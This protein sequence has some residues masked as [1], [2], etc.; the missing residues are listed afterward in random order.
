MSFGTNQSSS[1]QQSQSDTYYDPTQ[2]GLID[3]YVST[4]PTVASQLAYTPYTGPG[5]S[6]GNPSALGSLTSY[7]APTVSGSSYAPSTI[8]PSSVGNVQAGQIASTN[9]SPYMNPYTSDVADTTAAQLARQNQIQ[10]TNDAAQATSAGAFGGSRSAVLQSLDDDNYQ[11]DLN[12]T[13]AGLN[14][15]N[16]TQAQGAAQT[17]I[18]NQLQAGLQDQ[19]ADLAVDQANQSAA[20][21]AG[22]FGA[23]EAQNAAL[24]NQSAAQAAAQ[25]QLSALNLGTQQASDLYGANWQQYLN[26]QTA[27]LAVQQV[28]NQMYGLVPNKP[29]DQSD[30][31][32]TS[33]S[34]GVNFGIG[35]LSGAFNSGSNSNS[36]SNSSKSS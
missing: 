30:S 9:L 34:D 36:N 8:D 13:L 26:S 27:P 15:A 31:S 28:I 10:Q 14:Q 20:N 4:A 3:Q 32:S 16:F 1:Q 25:T 21:Q 19:Q 7:S 23:T 22:Q 24:A 11:R 6:F 2:T 5:L 18:A 33:Q 29:L 12:Q 17:D 35:P